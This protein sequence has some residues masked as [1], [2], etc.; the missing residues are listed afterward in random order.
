V[1]ELA[2]DFRRKARKAPQED[3][4][5]DDQSKEKKRND[6]TGYIAV[7]GLYHALNSPEKQDSQLPDLFFVFDKVVKL[8][9]CTRRDTVQML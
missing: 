5:G 3:R 7:H 4:Y 2:N 1:D 8:T 9:G 6:K